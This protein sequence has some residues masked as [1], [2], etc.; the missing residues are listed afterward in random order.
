MI[1]PL[2]RM[3]C[4]HIQQASKLWCATCGVDLLRGALLQR[5]GRR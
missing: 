2:R 5:A 1:N 4:P 3:V